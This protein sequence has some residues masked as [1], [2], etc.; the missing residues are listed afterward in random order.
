MT[1]AYTLP[2]FVGASLLFLIQPIIAKLLLPVFG[3]SAQVWTTSVMFF[4]TALLGGYAFAHGLSTLKHKNLGILIFCSAIVLSATIPLEYERHGLELEYPTLSLLQI[5]AGSIG[6][7][8]FLLSTCS[9]LL[10]HWLS[11]S[12]LRS[13][14]RP[15]FLYAVSNFGSLA[16]L[17]AYP[18]FIEPF[19]LLSEQ[20]DYWNT[21]YLVLAVLV[22]LAAAYTYFNARPALDSEEDES[23]SNGKEDL[24]LHRISRWV[25]WAF[26]PSGLML[27]V[28]TFLSN[29]IMP[30]PLLWI[31]P[32]FLYLL[33]LTIVFIPGFKLPIRAFV[34]PAPILIIASL[35]LLATQAVEPMILIILLFVVTLFVIAMIC[36]WELVQDKPSARHLTLF[37]LAVSFGGAL[38]GVFTALVSPLIF[39]NYYEFPLLLLLAAA[40]LPARRLAVEQTSTGSPSAALGLI[41]VTV[42]L[43]LVA[44][45]QMLFQ[46][47]IITRELLGFLGKI[48][49]I[50]IPFLLCYLTL[51]QRRRFV[52]S[53]FSCTLAGYLLYGASTNYDLIFQERT[54]YGVHR[55]L[56]DSLNQRTLLWHGGTIH[57]IQSNK[58]ELRGLPAAYFHPTSPA[59]DIFLRFRPELGKVAVVGLGAGTLSAYSRTGD[60]YDYYEIDPVVVDIA[61]N[62]QYFNYVSTAKK[63]NSVNGFTLG[64]ARLTLQNAADAHYDLIV[65]DA[66]S[67]GSPPTHLLTLESLTLYIDKLRTDGL[68]L[69]NISNNFLDLSGL[70]CS[71]AKVRNLN[72]MTKS[73]GVENES[74]RAQNKLPSIW[75]VMS[76][77]NDKADALKKLGWQEFA[78][79]P[80]ANVWTDNYSSI[81]HVLR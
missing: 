61:K 50:P 10:Q 81:L 74:Q 16:V 45:L 75:L 26:I 80:M 73:S 67:G 18:F 4:Q 70:L 79:S 9:P 28:T 37:Y 48:L 17:L 31:I 7:Q 21:L 72:C 34:L 63:R 47:S 40:A 59:G 77:D 69:F 25:F 1:W 22:I 38:G 12:N 6:I 29:E 20:I 68:I 8:F 76:E 44:L 52:I 24:S 23:L 51:Y 13:S 57:G 71:L 39:D 15:Y 60:Q 32:L 78:G 62:E 5:L 19:S 27:S 14:S 11:L 64:D 41:P 54:F 3:S 58:P 53:L 49:V 33:T 35:M 65:L 42:M 46:T 66:F 30:I 43:G 2:I 56:A 55:V 36:H